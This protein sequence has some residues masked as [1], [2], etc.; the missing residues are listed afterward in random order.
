MPPEEGCDSA[1]LCA[2]RRV[3]QA[4][5]AARSS[6]GASEEMVPLAAL[7]PSRSRCHFERVVGRSNRVH[8]TVLIIPTRA[9]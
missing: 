3:S 2:R 5:S 7:S 4:F 6:G 1:R 9:S 8:H